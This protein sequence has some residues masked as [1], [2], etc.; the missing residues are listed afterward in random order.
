MRTARAVPTPWLEENH[1][2]A[3]DLLLGPGAGDA[4]GAQWPDAGDFA[5]AIGFGF[6]DVENLVTECLHKLPGINRADAAD[7]AGGEILL[8]ALG[9]GNGQ[10]APLADSGR[11]SY[12]HR[13]SLY[14]GP[15]APFICSPRRCHGGAT[16]LC[17][18]S[19]GEHDRIATLTFREITH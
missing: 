10:S 4:L 14:R 7:H 5:Q 12:C 1:D 19:S 2:L 18:K 11:N 17:G 9:R 15:G 3:H 6:D 8:D 16:Q 13:R